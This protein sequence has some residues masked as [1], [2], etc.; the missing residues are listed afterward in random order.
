MALAKAA[1]MAAARGK[2]VTKAILNTLAC[3][4]LIFPLIGYAGDFTLEDLE[5]NTH[6]LTDYRGKWVLVNYWATWCPPCLNEIP[7][8]INLHSDKDNN[9]IVIGIAIQS[10]SSYKVA[11]F[12]EAHHMNYPIVMGSRDVTAQIGIANALP[13][14]FLYSPAGEMVSRH[15]GEL[16]QQMV[17]SAIKKHLN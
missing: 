3:L 10:G 16:T 2:M 15:D 17:E 5:G 13:M 1:I 7:E 9:L 8:L 6:R 14:S 12:A 11:D 4:T